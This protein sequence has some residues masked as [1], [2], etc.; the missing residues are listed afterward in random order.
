MERFIL[1][2]VGFSNRF[3]Y[4]QVK[5]FSFGSGQPD[6][7]V[8]NIANENCWQGNGVYLECVEPMRTWRVK[9]NGFLRRNA[10]DQYITNDEDDNDEADL[11]KN[12]EHREIIEA[13]IDFLWTALRHPVDIWHDS[14]IRLLADSLAREP[15]ADSTS[16]E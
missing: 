4:L 16:Y 9:F 5:V 2:Q 14:S 3:L 11:M 10:R 7:N 15:G 1:S 8:V 6:S 13:K 12:P